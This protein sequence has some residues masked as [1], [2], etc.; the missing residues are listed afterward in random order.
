MN[1]SELI[2]GFV[3]KGNRFGRSSITGNSGCAQGLKGAS[4]SS[5]FIRLYLLVSSDSELLGGEK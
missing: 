2:E 1:E 5:L 3:E 4:A